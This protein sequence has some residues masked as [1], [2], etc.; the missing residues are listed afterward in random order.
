MTTTTLSSY[1]DNEWSEYGS[2]SNKRQI[3]SACDGFTKSQRKLVWA[4]MNETKFEIVERLGLKAAQKTNYAHGGSNLVDTLT[5][6][7]KSFPA[8]NNVPLFEGE[9]QFGYCADP[10]ASAPRYI[11]CRVS[12]NFSNWFNKKDFDVLERV[13]DKGEE[14]EPKVMAPIAP[15]ILVNGGFGIGSGFSCSIP[16]YMPLD[17][18]RATLEAIDEGSVSTKLIPNWDWGGEM[19]TDAS[20]PNKFIPKGKYTKLSATQV[21][22]NCLPPSYKSSSYEAEVLIPL[23]ESEVISNFDNLSSE[24]DGW[25][26]VITFK[27]GILNQLSDDEIVNMLGLIHK[28]SPIN[29]NAT[30][31]SPSGKIK[32]YETIEQLIEDWA[33]WRISIYEKRIENELRILEAK[34]LF[35][36][37][38]IFLFEYI[39]KNN[40]FTNSELEDTI[41]LNFPELDE[42]SVEKL[43]N[44]PVRMITVNNIEK[45]YITIEKY[46]KEVSHLK[47]LTAEEY[48]RTELIDLFEFYGGKYE[49]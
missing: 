22:V 13:L 39:K 15:L 26:I 2:R 4:L 21:E 35:E 10:E 11:S 30:C 9:G 40:S 17:V 14:L 18:I 45:M 42:D 8:T 31:W 20:N 12:E 7:V 48:M 41:K 47:S 16:Q 34:I 6:M 3:P 33:F 1:I 36:R 25:K 38:K 23:L 28:K 43:L 19:L 37:A 32:K 49:R 46:E 24:L 44:I 27:R 5:G 29:I